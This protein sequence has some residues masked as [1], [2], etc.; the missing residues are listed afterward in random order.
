L[1]SK[2]FSQGPLAEL[3]L[4]RTQRWP[5]LKVWGT[6]LMKHVGAMKA[7]VAIARKIA[8]ILHCSGTDLT[9]FE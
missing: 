1:T 7:K 8:I 9:S 2:V 6:R 3:G 4:H 5:T